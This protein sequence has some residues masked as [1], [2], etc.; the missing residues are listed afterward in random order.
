MTITDAQQALGGRLLSDGT[1]LAEL[2]DLEGREI[3]ARAWHSQAVFEREL[4][5]VFRGAWVYVAHE[6]EIPEAGDFVARH[7][8]L[9]PVIVSRSATGSIQTMLNSCSHRGGQVCRVDKGNAEE[10]VCPYH[11]WRYEV[12]GTLKVVSAER[13]AFPADFDKSKYGL[14]RARTEVFNGLIFATWSDEAPELV[15]FLGDFG[16]YI[17]LMLAVSPDGWEVIGSPQRWEVKCNWKFGAEN[18][19]GDGYH[20]AF[21]HAVEEEAGRFPAGA[22]WQAMWGI[23]VSDERFGHGGRCTPPADGDRLGDEALMGMLQGMHPFL[24]PEKAQRIVESLDPRQLHLLQCGTFPLLGNVF[25][26]FSFVVNPIPGPHG[27][28]TTTFI[29]T[30]NPRT[31]ETMEVVNWV[32]APKGLSEEERRLVAKRSVNTFGSSGT[33]ENDDMEA[34]SQIQRITRG[35]TAQDRRFPYHILREPDPANWRGEES[36]PGPGLIYQGIATEDNQWNFWKSW[37][38][39]MV[40]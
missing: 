18:L 36:F 28:G 7:I 27:L 11:G 26:N 13:E 16:F 19:S 15:E 25:P 40:G 34:W 30:W 14:P 24:D 6:S 12:D 3:S 8:G 35:A 29:R 1:D 31:P 22:L 33:F 17:D 2:V 37:L 39:Y 21:V 23:N 32:I 38:R 9:D 20:V 5:T 4:E 10:L